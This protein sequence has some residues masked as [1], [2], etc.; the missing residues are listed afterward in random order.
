MRKSPIWILAI[1]IQP[2][3]WLRWMVFCNVFVPW[4]Q[5]LGW[6]RWT[7]AAGCVKASGSQHF[8]Q[9]LPAS[10]KLQ[11]LPRL[12]TDIARE[13]RLGSFGDTAA[14]VVSEL[15]DLKWFE[16]DFI[17]LLA[18]RFC[19]GLKEKLRGPLGCLGIATG[20]CWHCR[21]SLCLS[22]TISQLKLLTSGKRS[23]SKLRWLPSSPLSC[24][25][26]FAS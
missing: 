24:E 4:L 7:F 5:V 26:P 23:P 22:V 8:K 12:R 16:I 10:T 17:G 2:I 3:R 15:I 14:W 9:H 18:V 11:Q 19:G 13:L 6:Q 25:I 20:L 1:L 21:R